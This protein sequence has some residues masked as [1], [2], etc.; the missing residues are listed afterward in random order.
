MLPGTQTSPE[1]TTE[2]CQLQGALEDTRLHSPTQL[3]PGASTSQHP[4]ARR[5]LPSSLRREVR[6]LRGWMREQKTPPHTS[7]LKGFKG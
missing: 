3:L 5:P 6:A 4:E 2:G 7:N 1:I